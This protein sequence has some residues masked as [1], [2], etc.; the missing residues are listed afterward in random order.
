MKAIVWE[1]YN[2]NE[3]S[4]RAECWRWEVSYLNLNAVS[5]AL[6]SSRASCKRALKHFLLKYL[7]K[8]NA[9]IIFKDRSNQDFLL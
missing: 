1:I 8:P 2:P 4:F 7:E 6:Y 9:K 5:A 3:E